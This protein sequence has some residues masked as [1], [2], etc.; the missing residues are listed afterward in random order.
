MGDSSDE[1][2]TVRPLKRNSARADG[3][4]RRSRK[5]LDEDEEQSEDGDDI[6]RFA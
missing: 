5:I 2:I 6:I 4:S 1:D 3:A